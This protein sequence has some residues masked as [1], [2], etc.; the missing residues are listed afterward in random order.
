M[1]CLV[2]NPKDR[3]SR[4][5]AQKFQSTEKPVVE[6][7]VKSGMVG[8][9]MISHVRYLSRYI[10]LSMICIMLHLAFFNDFIHQPYDQLT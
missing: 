5:V 3:F 6:Y 10:P 9:R 7:D 4:G 1:S 2:A 8:N